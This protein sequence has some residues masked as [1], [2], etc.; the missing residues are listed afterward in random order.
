MKDKLE[1][2]APPSILRS[3]VRAT[4]QSP[5]FLQSLDTMGDQSAGVLSDDGE[6][7]PVSFSIDVVMWLRFP[8]HYLRSLVPPDT[9]R[10]R[11]ADIRK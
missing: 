2:S 10:R 4:H 11:H 5:H 8:S 9:A 7:C 1:S 3:Q 6:R